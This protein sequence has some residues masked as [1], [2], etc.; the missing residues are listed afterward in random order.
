MNL[1]IP[2]LK[3][4]P[5]FFFWFFLFI[6]VFGLGFNFRMQSFDIQYDETKYNVITSDGIGYYSYLPSTFINKEFQTSNDP[7]HYLN[8]DKDS[9][10]SQNKYFVGSSILMAPFFGLAHIYTSV[11]YW[12]SPTS[13]Y[14][15]NGYSFPYHLAI[16]LAGVFYLLLGLFYI[17]KIGLQLGIKKK[18]FVLFNYSFLLWELNLWS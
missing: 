5:E 13:G 6:I 18:Y 4:K 8:F 2:K 9:T 14:Y 3:I 15:P 17:K 16:C 12:I 1:S 7:N 11:D 10:T